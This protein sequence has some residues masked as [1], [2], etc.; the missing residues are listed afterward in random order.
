MSVVR[1]PG[2]MK[3]CFIAERRLA[4]GRIESID[5]QQCYSKTMLSGVLWP[6]PQPSD[7]A[8]SVH[9]R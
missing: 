9:G 2:A 3:V 4:S 8:V 6:P 1:R 7:P 5:T